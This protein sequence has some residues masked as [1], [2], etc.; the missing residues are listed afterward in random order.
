MTRILIVEDEESLADPLAFLLRKEGFD[1]II[2]GDGPTALVEFSRN[3]IDIVLLD[4]MLPGMSGTDVCKELRSVSTVPVI[5]VTARDSEIDKVV[6]LELGADDYVT[7][8]YSSRELIARIRAVL[9]RRGVTETEAEEL[10]LDD[11]ILEGGRVRM[12]VDSHTVTVGGE[13]VSMPLKEFDLLE[14]LLRNAGRVLTR[15]QLIDRIWGADYVGD[16]KTLD[17]HV[18]RLRSKIE[19]EPS[20]PRYLVTVRGLGYKFEL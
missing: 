5:M 11:Q 20:R 19:E 1:T 17:V 8:P 10:P 9:R 7:K 13:P 18:K 12:D 2:A 14:Y 16:T 6:G 15:G 3:E 4:L